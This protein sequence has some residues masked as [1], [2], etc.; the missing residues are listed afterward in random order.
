[1]TIADREADFYDLFA[2][3]RRQGSEFLI[4][5]TQ[6]RC[7]DSCEE[8]LWEKV[9][10]V[11][12]QGTMTVEVKRN[13]TRGATRATLSIRYTNVTLEPPTSRAKKEQLV[14]ISLQAILVTE[15][16]APPEIEP[17]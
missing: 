9:E 13:P 17:I 5:A 15:E 8:H 7:L 12:P 10:S 3:P 4:R 2:C 1:M 14:P 16:E 11:P 6:N